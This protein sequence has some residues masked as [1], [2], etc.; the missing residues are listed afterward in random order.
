M[1]RT[2]FS[3]LSV[4]QPRIHTRMTALQGSLF[5]RCTAPQTSL[6][7][8]LHELERS[9][10]APASAAT[11]MLRAGVDAHRVQRTCGTRR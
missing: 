10:A 4:H 2:F 7:K 11:L 6:N 9:G 3:D 1:D 8:H 5:S